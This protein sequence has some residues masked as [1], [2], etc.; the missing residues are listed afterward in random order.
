MLDREERE[1][2]QVD[3]EGEPERPGLPRIDRLRRDPEVADEGD[4]VQEAGEEDGVAGDAP[5]EERDA[6]RERAGLVACW[7]MA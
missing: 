6:R 4:G 2:A 1:Q 3:R 5:G 7:V